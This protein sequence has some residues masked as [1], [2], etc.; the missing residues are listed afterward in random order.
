MDKI[1]TSAVIL[2]QRREK[3]NLVSLS[4]MQTVVSKRI[5]KLGG[6]LFAALALALG[7][8]GI[9]LGRFLR[10]NSWDV[11]FDAP[12][13]LAD[14][15][16]RLLYPLAHRQAYAVTLLFFVFLFTCYLIVAPARGGDAGS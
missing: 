6:W 5:G 4:T 14:V 12:T 2:R 7:S 3:S 10:W 16:V 13:V 1:L 9:Y 11:F 8:L 15:G